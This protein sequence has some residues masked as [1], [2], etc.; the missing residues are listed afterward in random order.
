MRGARAQPRPGIAAATWSGR[1]PSCRPWGN[2]GLEE[3]GEPVLTS[4]GRLLLLGFLLY[5]HLLKHL[6]I[7]IK[8]LES[9]FMCSA[10]RAVRSGNVLN[11]DQGSDFVSRALC[12]V[13]QTDQTCKTKIET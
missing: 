1:E 10:Q 5:F 6:G 3:A 7:L 8:P 12:N 4:D 13:Y 11:E 9:N 2:H